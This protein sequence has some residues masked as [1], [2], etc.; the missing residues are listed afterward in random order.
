M[1]LLIPTGWT[2][3]RRLTLLCPPALRLSKP[4]L[5][6]LRPGRLGE[7]GRLGHGD[8]HS[9]SRPAL[10]ESLATE[11]ITQ[12]A[13]GAA[14]SVAVT[15]EGEAFTW[16]WGFTGALGHGN[17]IDCLK[18]TRVF[19]PD[20]A[21]PRDTSGAAGTQRDTHST[22]GADD[23]TG[24]VV[25]CAQ[26]ERVTCAAAAKNRTVLGTS[27]GRV[28]NSVHVGL[29]TVSGAG[30]VEFGR[31]P[32]GLR[33]WRV[34]TSF[35]AWPNLTFA[36]DSAGHAHTF[37]DGTGN[38]RVSFFSTLADEGCNSCGDGMSLGSGGKDGEIVDRGQDCG[39]EGAALHPVSAAPLR[40]PVSVVKC[41]SVFVSPSISVGEDNHLS[42][43][44][45]GVRGWGPTST[46]VVV[47][48]NGSL[49]TSASK[50]GGMHELHRRRNDGVVCA[51]VGLNQSEPSGLLVVD[52]GASLLTWG[53]A[54]SGQ[55]RRRR[56][57]DDDASICT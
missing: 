31:L 42:F 52:G 30:F 37:A 27:R 44:P 36:I 17:E 26:I 24:E 54:I 6:Q 15:W 43:V 45:D 18:P 50:W 46:V 49:M 57:C 23:S 12:V 19:L 25:G 32:E 4:A 7:Y 38:L 5:Y 29:S 47:S 16:G 33:L 13:A 35:L 20:D 40:S 11:R 53:N 1:L 41:H 2:D 14:H 34:E 51:A 55:V 56:W 9:L 8:E 48:D 3:G 21:G 28:L 39:Q 22:L 10:I